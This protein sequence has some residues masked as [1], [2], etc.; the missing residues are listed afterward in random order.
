MWRN[1]NRQ[2]E[3]SN[4]RATRDALV[5]RINALRSALQDAADR[6]FIG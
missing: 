4:E 3:S 5:K 2:E 6:T 1:L